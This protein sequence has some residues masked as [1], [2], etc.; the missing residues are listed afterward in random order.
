MVIYIGLPI[1]CMLVFGCYTRRHIHRY[2][3]LQTQYEI[4]QPSQ[5]KRFPI[6]SNLY[7]SD[8]PPVQMTAYTQHT[9]KKCTNCQ[10]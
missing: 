2:T 3:R 10:F 6:V 7:N 1:Y 8:Y 5:L 9:I 4:M